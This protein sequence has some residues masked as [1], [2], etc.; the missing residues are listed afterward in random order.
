MFSGKNKK[1]GL[2]GRPSNEV[3]LLATSKLYM[4]DDQ[5]FAFMP[6]VRVRLRQLTNTFRF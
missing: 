4:M 2:T 3:G 6:Q 5:L 1:L